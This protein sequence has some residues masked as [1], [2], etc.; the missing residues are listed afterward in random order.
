MADCDRAIELDPKLA[1]A[2]A[3]R[4]GAYGDKE[5]YR[6]ALADCDRA[7]ELDPKLAFAYANRGYVYGEKKD[8]DRALADDDKAIELDP[9]SVRAAVVYGNRGWICA[10]KGYLDKAIANYDTAIELRPKFAAH[11]NQRCWFRAIDAQA[12]QSQL[13]QALA[14]CS[15]ALRLKYNA[16]DSRGFVY[17]KL[18]E[19]DRAITDYDAELKIDPKYAGSLYGRGIAKLKK[20]DSTG[21][22]DINSAKAIQS[23]IAEEF[24]GYGVK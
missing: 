3:Y 7:I 14:D 8:Y 24:A 21:N 18:G 4:C 17:L 11:Y 23:D 5:D 15:E 19:Y 6:G 10:H 12:Q 1:S 20:G 13:Q 16:L 9:K 2:Y 22:A